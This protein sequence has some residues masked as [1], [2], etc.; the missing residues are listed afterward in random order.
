MSE[1]L[2]RKVENNIQIIEPVSFLEMIMLEKYAE[3]IITDS[4]GVQKEAF[5]FNKPCVIL[6]AETEWVELVNAGCAIIADADCQKIIDSY[7]HFSKIDKIEFPEIFGEGQSAEFIC[8]EIIK[9]F[10]I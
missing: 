4:G 10:G 7:L 6:R 9:C 8:K 1:E 2:L 3:M 5:F